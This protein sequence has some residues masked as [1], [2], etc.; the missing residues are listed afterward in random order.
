MLVLISNKGEILQEDLKCDN[1]DARLK[2][3]WNFKT[4]FTFFFFK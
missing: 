3:L 2:R 4:N 1:E